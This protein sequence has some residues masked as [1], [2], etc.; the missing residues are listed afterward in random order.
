MKPPK[1]LSPIDEL[2]QALQAFKDKQPAIFQRIVDALQ[3]P[4][5]SAPDDTAAP[6]QD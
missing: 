3:R 2:G 6:R 5:P 1:K 4:R